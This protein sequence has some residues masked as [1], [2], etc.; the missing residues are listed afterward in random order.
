MEKDSWTYGYSMRIKVD[1]SI[2]G[3]LAHEIT[4]E[5]GSGGGDCGTPLP[6]GKKF[7][8]FAYKEKDG[9]LWTGMCSGNWPLDGDATDEKRIAE[10]RALVASKHGSIFGDAVNTTPVWRDDDVS[11]AHPRPVAAMTLH[12]QSSAFNATTKTSKDGTYEFE[13]LPAG[14]YTIVPDTG[15]KLDFDHEYPNRYQA[16][17]GE[18]SC[19]RISFN[20]QPT[21]RIRGHLSVPPISGKH[22]WM[23]EALPTSLKKINQYSGKWDI[24][25]EDGNFDLWPLPPGDYYL[26]LNINGSPTPDAPLLPTYYPGVLKRSEAQVIHIEEGEVKQLDLKIHDLAKPR[27]V[28]FVATGADGKPLKTVYIQTE[29]LRHPGDA[30]SYVNVDLDA[31]G[32]GTMVVYEGFNYHL[33]ASHYAGNKDMCAKPVVIPDGAGSLQAQFHLDIDGAAIYD[34]DRIKR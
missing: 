12:A 31:Q 26:G 13:G 21:T 8:I 19:A 32:A 4:V 9:K 20:L 6:P 5:T 34:I 25:G 30:V 7:F 33:H 29:D 24:V 10:Y 23:V 2:R 16:E 14:T 15:G 27:T 11:D 3:G 18:G 1:E 28:Q 17:V 22:S